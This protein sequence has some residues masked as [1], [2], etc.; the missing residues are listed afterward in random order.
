MQDGTKKQE[1][2]EVQIKIAPVNV[3]YDINV[4]IFD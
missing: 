2:E 4:N 3:K 1:E